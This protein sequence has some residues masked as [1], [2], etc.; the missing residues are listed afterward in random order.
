MIVQ[1]RC[2]QINQSD[3]KENFE[4]SAE[5]QKKKLLINPIYNIIG[6]PGCSKGKYL[7]KQIRD[8]SSQ[9]LLDSISITN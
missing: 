6:K 3:F 8:L 5:S 2:M 4:K 9:Q 1:L 7:E